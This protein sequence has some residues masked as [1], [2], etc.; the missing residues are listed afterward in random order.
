MKAALPTVGRIA[1]NKP[2][3]DLYQVGVTGFEPATSTSRTYKRSVVSDNTKE[4]RA[5]PLTVC[6]RVC[7]SD[8]DLQQIATDLRR[9]FS[10]EECQRLAELLTANQTE[11]GA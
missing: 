11:G 2:R 5:T 3:R 10:A 6:T 9:Q 8:A 4:V 1:K 7:T